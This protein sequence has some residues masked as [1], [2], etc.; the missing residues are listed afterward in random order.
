M[1]Q[2]FVVY[3]CAGHVFPR[4]YKIPKG[5]L[6]TTAGLAVC[7]PIISNNKPRGPAAGE[8]I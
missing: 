7:I 3:R 8:F 4:I 5:N 6:H 1:A 2:P